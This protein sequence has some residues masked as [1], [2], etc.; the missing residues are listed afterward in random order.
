M[1]TKENNIDDIPYMPVGKHKGKRV[2][3]LPMSYLRWML[4]K[5]FPEEI[6]R[7]ARKK[8][9]EV[10]VEIPMQFT[11]H[12]VDSFSLRHLNRWVN[13]EDK[14]IGM[15]RFLSLLAFEAFEKGEDVSKNR[16]DEEQTIKEY[17]GMRF[18]FNKDGELRVL[19]TVF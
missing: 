7:V 2:D 11:S 3:T 14:K 18:V 15:G 8:V 12:A 9:G 19:I 4:T 10:P 1:D 13:R 17:K 16:H 6:L 5:P